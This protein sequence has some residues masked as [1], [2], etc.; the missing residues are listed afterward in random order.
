M[1]PQTRI[2]AIVSVLLFYGFGIKA[3]NTNAEKSIQSRNHY[4]V[5]EFSPNEYKFGTRPIALL[6]DSQ[7]YLWVGCGNGLYR[8]DGYDFEKI[9]IGEGNDLGFWFDRNVWTLD[10]D[11]YGN[12]WGW[13]IGGVFNFNSE[14]KKVYR[15]DVPISN[16]SQTIYIDQE[17]GIWLDDAWF[18]RYYSEKSSLKSDSTYYQEF[19]EGKNQQFPKTLYKYFIENITDTVAAFFK[20]KNNQIISK[21]FTTDKTRDLI[22]LSMGELIPMNMVPLINDLEPVPPNGKVDYGWITNS[23]GDTIWSLEYSKTFHAGGR[24]DNRV[25]IKI[26]NFPPDRYT[27]HYK[28][29]F[30]HSYEK[31]EGGAPNYKEFWGIQLFSNLNDSIRNSINSII[32]TAT[33]A[34]I[35]PNSIQGDTYFIEDTTGTLWVGASNG[36]FKSIKKS[37]R[38]SF[39]LIDR[40]ENNS[41]VIY[42]HVQISKGPNQQFLVS[43]IISTLEG[44]KKYILE[45]FNPI[46]REFITL[47]T[48]EIDDHRDFTGKILYD[49]K[50]QTI[51]QTR[52]DGNDG[53]FKWKPPYSNGPV[54]AHSRNPNIPLDKLKIRSFCLDDFDNLWLGTFNGYI[55]KVHLGHANLK[56]YS[57]DQFSQLDKIPIINSFAEDRMGKIWIGS[58]DHKIMIYDPKTGEIKALDMPEMRLRRAY[59]RVF[60][61]QENNIWIS[62]T[63]GI[64]L[65]NIESE[66]YN[67]FKIPNYDSI[68]FRPNALFN[69]IQ[70]SSDGK[71]W[72]QITS[73]NKDRILISFDANTKTFYKNYYIPFTSRSFIDQNNNL[74]TGQYS[75][76]GFY[77]L[78]KLP[79]DSIDKI[80]IS[81]GYGDRTLILNNIY[82]GLIQDY[83]GD[84]WAGTSNQGLARIDPDKGL[85]ERITI[86]NDLPSNSVW[87]LLIGNNGMIW[88]YTA[89]GIVSYDSENK[90]ISIPRELN[91]IR[92]RG[93]LYK[94]SSNH[95]YVNTHTKRGFYVFYPD[96][97]SINSTMPHT[98]ITN[99]EINNEEVNVTDIS[100][101]SK[102]ISYTK[103]ISLSY[104]QNSFALE[105]RGLHFDNP[106]ANQYAYKMEPISEEWNYVGDEKTAR[107]MDLAPGNYTFMVKS[108]NPD[109]IWSEPVSLSITITPS[110]YWNIW[111]QI[112][113]ALIIIGVTYAFYR[114]RTQEA[115]RRFIREKR[116]N[117]RLQKVDELKDQ[118]L[119][120]TSHE[121]RTPL[122]GIIGLAESLQDG[123]AGE[124][125]GKAKYNLNMIASSGKRLSHLINDILDFSKL[126]SA[127]LKLDIRVLDLH[128]LANVVLRLCTPLA[129]AKGLKLINSVPE[130]ITAVLVDE[131]RIQQILF[132]IVG[133]GIKF[134]DS[135]YVKIDAKEKENTVEVTIEDTGIGIPENKLNTIFDSFVQVEDSDSRQ[136]GGTGLGLSITKKL[137]ELHGGSIGVESEINIGSRFIITLKRA[138]KTAEVSTITKS[139]IIKK[140]LH[141]D[142]ET[143]VEEIKPKDSNGIRVLIV[144]DEPVNLQVLNNQLTMQGYEVTEAHSGSEALQ[145]IN[146][147]VKFDLILLD[148]MMPKMS[149]Y[150]V[151]EKLRELYLPNELPIVMVTA[152]TGI[153][154]I[155]EGLETGAND[156]LTKPFSKDELLSRIKTHLKLHNINKAMGKFVPGQFL[157][158]IGRDS[159]MDVRLGDLANHQDV[160]VFFS[161]IRDFTHISESMKPEEIFAFI[162]EYNKL[163]GPIILQH[164]GFINQYQ[165]DSIMAVFTNSN[166]SALKASI[167]IQKALRRFNFSAK[168]PCKSGIGLHTGPLVLGITGDEERLDTTVIADTVNVTAR[169]ENLT[170]HYGVKILVSED[171]KNSL[172]NEKKFTFRYLGEVRP[173]GKST[174]IGLYECLEGESDE[175]LSL[176]IKSLKQFEEGINSYFKKEFPKASVLF[177]EVLKTYPEDKT[178]KYYLS[179]TGSLIAGGVSDDWTGIQEI[180]II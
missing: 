83:R 98:L 40:S 49:E 162:N 132:N 135:G 85:I 59:N 67:F 47:Y 114:W 108:A 25:Q 20:V 16:V 178:A 134:T 89:H 77:G 88:M 51:W 106:A 81:L 119:A 163:I 61:D 179:Q 63:H 12:I 54:S 1:Q 169:I 57:I 39:E 64:H 28:S 55:Y 32:D 84:L 126:K 45:L 111:T 97:L 129:E 101:L 48:K 107:F 26:Q 58:N 38:K 144:D 62:G 103:E 86:D 161:D 133:N 172:A 109:G 93:I 68:S 141:E 94:S 66:K 171:F 155:V 125:P 117:I 116:M 30:A 22:I 37:G 149:G 50:T 75:R 23:K 29:D 8:Y 13:G 80:N 168:I 123:V 102:S 154:D 180:S 110:W 122:N 151:C 127:E 128:S 43:G 78:I 112:I 92:G 34:E 170:K 10:E 2:L 31:W 14:N 42:N 142:E 17:D 52:F 24:F 6:E 176:K 33:Y 157:K 5:E 60:N 74:W 9:E 174:Q 177:E 35:Y 143:V 65:Y 69:F 87:D 115:R 4:H 130:E 72:G 156:Y 166:D 70:Q 100:V 164:K 15:P 90:R 91:E 19:I 36:L 3:Q 120:N 104:T 148:I 173:K 79:L 44:E 95:I 145:K 167:Q 136:F 11:Q 27:L 159:I 46:K 7:G 121:L 158:A 165:G 147:E 124:L 140:G 76:A 118:F 56:F 73:Q 113:Y 175:N 138:D 139:S 71:I 153:R 137:V 99:L 96:S 146:N 41:I 18:I 131:N 82:N 105:Y 53:L 152:K 150:E 160:T 21:S